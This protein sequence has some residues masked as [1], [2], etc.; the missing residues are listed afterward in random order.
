MVM[1]GGD[2]EGMEIDITTQQNNELIR[3]RSN[4]FME[5][6]SELDSE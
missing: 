6:Q 3:I 4:Q 2:D 1:E 5:E